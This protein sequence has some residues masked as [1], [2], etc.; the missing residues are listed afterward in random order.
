MLQ[1]KVQES[2]RLEVK[3]WCEPSANKITGIMFLKELPTSI[4]G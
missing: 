4:C 1:N 3:V 2:A